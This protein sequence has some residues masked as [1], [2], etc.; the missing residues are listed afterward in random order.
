MLTKEYIEKYFLT[1]KQD[2]MML[3]IAGGIAIALALFMLIKGNDSF[4]KGVCIILALTG[5]W[6]MVMGY[7]GFIHSDAH[8]I[9]MVY[10]YDMN[11]PKLKN[12]EM[13]RMERVIKSLR[14][15]RIIEACFFFAGLVLVFLFFSNEERAIWYGIGL[16]LA[17]Q[18]FVIFIMD[19]F[20]A[21][22]AEQYWFYLKTFIGNQ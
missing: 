2:G 18:A 17:I 15:S 3:I 5:I 12:E 9:E 13:P 4:S 19:Q 7:P 14:N 16:G 20:A 10:A 8:R 1:E 22:R 21:K 11:P 6:Q